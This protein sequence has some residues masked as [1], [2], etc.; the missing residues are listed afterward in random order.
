MSDASLRLPAGGAGTVFRQELRA[1][2][3]ATWYRTAVTA[4]LLVTL[5]VAG[6]AE[7]NR[8]Q[9]ADWYRAATVQGVAAVPP[10]PLSTLACGLSEHLERHVVFDASGRAGLLE[11]VVRPAGLA[12]AWPPWSERG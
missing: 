4:A 11:A 8:G 6:F 10:A 5:A 3:R 12:G 7:W 9:R 2:A 1:A